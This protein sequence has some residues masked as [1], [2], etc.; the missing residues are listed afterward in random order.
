VSEQNQ[1]VVLKKRSV[2]V[3]QP[4]DF[5]L[6]TVPVA[7]PGPGQLLCQAQYLTL[8]PYL[9][10]K[11]SGRHIS[12]A[13]H[14][15]DMMAGEVVSSVVVSND[16]RFAVGDTIAAFSGWQTKPVIDGDAARRIE[17]HG[18]PI[19]TA[20]GIMGMPGLTAY[21]GTL[22]L[23]QPEP[24]DRVLVSAAAGPV[25]S[26]VGQIARIKGAHPIGIA[27]SDEKCA[28]LKEQAGFADCINYKKEDL[29]EGIARTC[30]DGV[31][32]YFDNV[33]GDVLQAA[34]EH[35]A[36]GARVVLC[37]LMAQ[38]N[39]DDMPPGP[40]PAFIIKARA[41]VRGLVVYDHEDLRGEFESV[42][43]TWIRD[44][45]LKF[46]EDIADGIERA[47]AAFCA[48]MRGENFGKALVR[49]GA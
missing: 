4:D 35:L 5:E 14:P 45:E 21:A 42:V 12:G 1:I 34:M 17:T 29:R 19:S 27:G 46:K 33:G 13:I 47:P 38:Y 22:R 49:L 6:N 30:P 25:G 28:W 26:T 32:M 43:G 10:G 11:I 16:P 8:D 23:G 40:N 20:L 39:R 44:G 15:G 18:A 31:N 24:G 41:T 3:P 48:L 2:G 7:D 37:G 9:R 36:L